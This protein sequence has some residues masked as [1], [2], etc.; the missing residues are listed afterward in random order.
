MQAAELLFAMALG[1]LFL[2]EAWP[3]GIASVGA[4]IVVAGILGFAWL[5]SRPSPMPIPVPADPH[6]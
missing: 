5:V 4:W 3:V 6:A 2:G 1:A